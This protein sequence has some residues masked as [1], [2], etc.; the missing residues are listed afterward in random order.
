MEEFPNLWEHVHDWVKT[1]DPSKFDSWWDE[2]QA[3]PMV[4]LSFIDYLK[5][6]WMPIVPLWVGLAQKYC[7]IF[8]EG[9]TNMLIEL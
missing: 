3:N 8:Q 6:N 2:M 4:P 5:V 9:D 1:P 7:M